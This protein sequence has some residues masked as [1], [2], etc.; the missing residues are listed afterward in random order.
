MFDDS[1]PLTTGEYDEWGIQIRRS[2]TTTWSYSPYDNV[3]E[4]NYPNMYVSQDYMIRKYW[5]PAKMVY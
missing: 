4:Q 2:I 5:E 3:K 1:I